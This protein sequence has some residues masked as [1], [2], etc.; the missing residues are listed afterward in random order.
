MFHERKKFK[1]CSCDFTLK[2]IIY[3]FL[4]DKFTCFAA[5]LEEIKL[6]IALYSL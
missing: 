4:P 5:F 2:N 6:K 3:L 1:N